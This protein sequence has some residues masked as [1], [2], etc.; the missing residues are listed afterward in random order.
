MTIYSEIDTEAVRRRIEALRSEHRDLDAA[1]AAFAAATPHNSLQLQ[2][3]KKRKLALKDQLA[4][5][6]SLL[7]PNIIA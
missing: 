2:R 3:L 7:L 1:I 4:K 6:E 5:L